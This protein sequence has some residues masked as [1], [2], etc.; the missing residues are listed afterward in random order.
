M[1]EDQHSFL[2]WQLRMLRS[3]DE[4]FRNLSLNL[5]RMEKDFSQQLAHWRESLFS[6]QVA[7]WVAVIRHNTTVEKV[8]IDLSVSESTIWKKD[9]VKALILAIRSLPNLRKLILR[10][11]ILGAPRRLA[12]ME[13][14]LAGI[15]ENYSLECFEL[16]GNDIAP[17]QENLLSEMAVTA[18]CMQGLESFKLLGFRMNAEVVD[19]FLPVMSIP[20]LKEFC[21]GNSTESFVP[22]AQYLKTNEKIEKLALCFDERVEDEK[23]TCLVE[24]LQHNTTL[25]SLSLLNASTMNNNAGI[26]AQ[27]QRALVQLTMHNMTL[28]EVKTRGQLSEEMSMFLKLNRKGRRATFEGGTREHWVDALISSSDDLDCAFYFLAMNPSV[29][30]S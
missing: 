27:S 19:M 7:Q 29:C 16:W 1:Y 6:F 14:I 24:A 11:N 2:D 4:S 3:N 13:A 22:V 12:S 9:Q 26:S 15:K 30:V 18:R 8:M 17:G 21:L 5:N 25:Q 10:Q 20:S 28:Q 23:I